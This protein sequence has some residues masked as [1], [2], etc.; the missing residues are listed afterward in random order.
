[1]NIFQ[2]GT[3]VDD[4]TPA[5]DELATPVEAE[6]GATTETPGEGTEESV[7]PDTSAPVE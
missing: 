4:G 7:E 1:M 6:A 2:S 3:T 5:E